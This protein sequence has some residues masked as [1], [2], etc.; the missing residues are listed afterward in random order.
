MT[1]TLTRPAP[2]Y[3]PEPPPQRRNVTSVVLGVVTGMAV[4][5]LAVVALVAV[6]RNSGHLAMM[7]DH[8][9]SM[10]G[11]G[12]MMNGPMMNGGTMMGQNQTPHASTPTV[13]GAREV[14]V[15]ATSYGFTPNEIHVTVNE[16]VTIVLAATDVAHDFTIDELDV[17]V[18][19]S[20]GQVGRGGLHAPATPGRYTAYCSIADDRSAGMTA[21]VIVDAA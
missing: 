1:D 11:S 10:M 19:A 6:N 18:A 17:H 3:E 12:Q 14:A 5:A 9:A 15:S 2:S 4:I 13:P 8:M 20:P 7:N 16:D 21:T